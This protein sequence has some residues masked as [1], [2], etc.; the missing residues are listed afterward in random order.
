ML[1]F[2]PGS[3]QLFIGVSHAMVDTRKEIEIGSISEYFASVMGS[4]STGF[5]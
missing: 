1:K 5:D 2:E 4:V 3:E